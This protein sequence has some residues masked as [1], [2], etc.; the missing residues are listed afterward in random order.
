MSYRKQYFE[1]DVEANEVLYGTPVGYE[2]E[3]AQ[4]ALFYPILYRITTFEEVTGEIIQGKFYYSLDDGETWVDY[5]LGE[6]GMTFSQP[7]KM[8]LVVRATET[9]YIFAERDAIIYRITGD[10]SSIID[11]YSI[12]NVDV[13]SEMDIQEQNDVLCLLNNDTLYRIYVGESIEPYSNSLNLNSSP[14]S[15]AI[16]S[17][18]NSFWEINPSYVCLKN[19]NGEIEFCVENPLGPI[20]VDVESSTSS[21]SSIDS[22]S[23]STTSSSSVGYSSSSSSKDSSSTSSSSRGNSSSSS[24]S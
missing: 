11:T 22:S 6:N 13:F 12:N 21:S 3:F 17:Y 18:R 16:D 1:W 14:V 10:A 24:S 2:V 19:L 23:S 20:D 8:R 9:G 4:N 15:V 7:Y 5:P